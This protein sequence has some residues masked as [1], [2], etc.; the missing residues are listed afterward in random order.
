MSK[1]LAPALLFALSLTSSAIWGEE[2]G[3]RF[4][5]GDNLNQQVIASRRSS[6]Q[7]LGLEVVKW[8]Q[9]TFVSS[10]AI[11]KVN[12][13]GSL[14]A[15]QTIKAA[16][17]IDADP[18]LR[19]PMSAALLKTQGIKLELTVRPNGDVATLKAPK[20]T[21]QVLMGGDVA[22]GQSLRLW[23]LLDADAWKELDGRTFFLPEKPL[24]SQPSLAQPAD[25]EPWARDLAHD[26]GALG[27]WS[28]KTIYTDKG[29][30]R[31]KKDLERIEYRHDLTYKS[32]AKGTDRDLPLRVLKT[33]FKPLAAG[34][35][36]LFDPAARKVTAVEE[37]FR[38]RGTA[39]VSV[40]GTET[41]IDMEELQGFRINVA[42]A[43]AKKK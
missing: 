37:T 3:P 32:P 19:A 25:R 15:E 41:T 9:Y 20:D 10:F 22:V 7:V 43:L 39:V 23:S 14:E 24:R 34:G 30:E 28:G 21:I 4:K 16:R 33:E 11:T 2:P 27:S 36:M 17:L 12:E 38:V 40:G 29:K 26:W 18:D 31:G 13:D 8:A 1:R 5:V 6:F 42:E 35:V